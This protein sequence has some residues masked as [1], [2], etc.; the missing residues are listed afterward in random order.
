ME[1][2][3]VMSRRQSEQISG[4]HYDTPRTISSEEVMKPTG[5]RKP[6]LPLKTGASRRK[7]HRSETRTKDPLHGG[8]FASANVHYVRFRGASYQQKRTLSTSE[9]PGGTEARNQVV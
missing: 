7:R 9:T 4:P 8:S 3:A 5:P 6:W 2:I 1:T